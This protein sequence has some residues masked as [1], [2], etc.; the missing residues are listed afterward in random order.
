MSQSEVSRIRQQIAAEYQSA[1]YVFTGFTPTAKHEFLTKRN[2]NIANHFEE[3]QKHMP[4]E[5]AMQI[6]IEESKSNLTTNK[7]DS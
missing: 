7:Q 3:L 2:E 6:L 1:Q 5:A 4:P